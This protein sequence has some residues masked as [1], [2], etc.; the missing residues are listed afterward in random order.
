MGLIE[1][2]TDIIIKIGIFLL[3]AVGCILIYNYWT[4]GQFFVAPP[5]AQKPPGPAGNLQKDQKKGVA[6]AAGAQS[7]V[8]APVN[9]NNI[10]PNIAEVQEETKKEE[11]PVESDMEEIKITSI[12]TLKVKDDIENSK[13][14]I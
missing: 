14:D 5:A 9:S 4:T 10:L 12:D 13:Y 11:I 6:G 1:Y 7:N 8:Q 2:N 3:L